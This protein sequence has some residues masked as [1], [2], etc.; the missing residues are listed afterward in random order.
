[1]KMLFADGRRY[2]GRVVAVNCDAAGAPTWEGAD[3]A[4][5]GGEVS[6][7][8][9]WELERPDARPRAKNAKRK[10][11]SKNELSSQAQAAMA[12]ALTRLQEQ[13]PDLAALFD[14]EVTDDVAPGYSTEVPL[15][16]HLQL[17]IGRLEH[18]YYRH[19]DAVAADLA[20]IASNCE[21]F[22]RA[23]APISA[24]ARSF[25][26]MAVA[27]VQRAAAQVEAA[28]GKRQRA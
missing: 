19:A 23:D 20:L 21:L 8:N 3:I 4:W 22:N 16:M 6:S 17:I 18:Q 28:G 5:D 9:L 13:E 1:M 15:P 25:V 7:V 27:A 24:Q 12:T 26:G 2:G 14:D 11:S 10:S